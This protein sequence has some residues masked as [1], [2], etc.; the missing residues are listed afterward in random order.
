MHNFYGSV[1]TPF[2][3]RV[4]KYKTAIVRS[5]ALIVMKLTIPTVGQI[6]PSDGN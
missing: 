3:D 4:T 6:P 1:L 2:L 5:V